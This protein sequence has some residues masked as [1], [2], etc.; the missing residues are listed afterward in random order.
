MFNV[1]AYICTS[2]AVHV[3]Q[4]PAN[5]GTFVSGEIILEGKGC[6]FFCHAAFIYF[7][8]FSMR[9]IYFVNENKF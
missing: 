9:K 7:M 8:T 1:H 3:V 6:F 5:A 2:Y 4:S